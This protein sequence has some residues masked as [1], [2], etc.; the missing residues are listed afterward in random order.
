MKES[1]TER[2]GVA[3]NHDEAE[4]PLALDNEET[5]LSPASG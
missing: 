1:S 5:S 4:A 2:A 3:G